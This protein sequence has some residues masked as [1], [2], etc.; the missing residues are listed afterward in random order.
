MASLSGGRW[1]LETHSAYGF[2]QAAIGAMIVVSTALRTGP[3]F[4]RDLVDWF[5]AT[6]AGAMCLGGIL[7]VAVPERF[8]PEEVEPWQTGFL[9]AGTAFLAVAILIQLGIVPN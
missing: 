1:I 6:G 4:P 3:G 8:G 5:L 7:V 9:I 2:L